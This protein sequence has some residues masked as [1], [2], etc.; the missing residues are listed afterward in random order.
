MSVYIQG[1]TTPDSGRITIQIGHDGAVYLV[2]KFVLYKEQYLQDSKATEIQ[3]H[4]KLIDADAIKKRIS[5]MNIE[6][7]MDGVCYGIHPSLEYLDLLNEILDDA[8]TI[9]P[10]SKE[11]TNG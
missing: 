8:P 1:I 9:I 2:N 4:G 11:E 6:A 7:Y 3:P 5:H 10:A